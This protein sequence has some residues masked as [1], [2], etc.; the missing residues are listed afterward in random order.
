MPITKSIVELMNGAIQVKSQKGQ[1]TTF[2]VT[3]L[4][5]SGGAAR[6]RKYSPARIAATTIRATRAISHLLLFVF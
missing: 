2:T 3:V 4:S 1:G 6:K 5:P